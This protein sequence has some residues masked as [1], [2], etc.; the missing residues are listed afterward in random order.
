MI[1]RR[2]TILAALVA[3]MA[4]VS[5]AGGASGAIIISQYVEGASFDKY[6]E[7]YNSGASTV[8]LAA[9][10]YKL[11]HFNNDNREGWK[12]D[13]SPTA[14]QAL[15]GTIA[16]GETYVIAHS[17]AVLPEYITPNQADGSNG[18]V[19]FNG[20]D[21]VV[22]WT[23]T[24]Y[25]FAGVVDAFGVTAGGFADKSFVRKSTIGVGTKLDF[26]PNDWIEYS[27]ADVNVALE[28]WVERL[29]YHTAVPEPAAIGGLAML[30]VAV[31]PRRRRAES[32]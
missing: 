21:S 2:S 30:A 32:R 5:T 13:V 28:G 15:T 3:G 4:G 20:D 23:G 14:T 12:T 18:G 24:T 27:V 22:L 6:I 11:S 26:N 19:N 8:D 9:G 16:P 25:S 31:L 29:G 10:N 17:S 1:M 7:L